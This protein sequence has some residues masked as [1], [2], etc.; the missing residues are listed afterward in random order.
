MFTHPLPHEIF[1]PQLPSIL[2]LSQVCRDWKLSWRNPTREVVPLLYVFLLFFSFLN[3]VIG[4]RP[5]TP[6]RSL[7]ST[8]LYT[9]VGGVLVNASR[10]STL[11]HT[12]SLYHITLCVSPGT[13]ESHC[14]ATHGMKSRD[15]FHNENPC[16]SRFISSYWVTRRG[17]Q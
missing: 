16:C 12:V 6:V 9:V 10:L 8:P 15:S 4:S 7:L 3:S 1:K 17:S 11:P 14:G 5:S 2:F 13:L